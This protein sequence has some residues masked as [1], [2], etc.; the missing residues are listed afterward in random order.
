MIPQL[1][2]LAVRLAP[3][4]MLVCGCAGQLQQLP[5]QAAA[6]AEGIV[7]AASAAVLQE[8]EASATSAPGAPSWNDFAKGQ[9]LSQGVNVAICIGLALVHD[10][11]AKLPASADVADASGHVLPMVKE[12]DAGACSD[13]TLLLAHDRAVDFLEAHGVKHVHR[14][15]KR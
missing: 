12:A 2:R 15:A 5:A 7:P 4:V 8:A 6:C 13:S 10:L 11:D 1:L 3:I 9:L 14:R